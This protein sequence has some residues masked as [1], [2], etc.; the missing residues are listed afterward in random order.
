MQL[1]PKI[2]KRLYSRIAD[3]L[4]LRLAELE[5]ELA[6]ERDDEVTDYGFATYQEYQ[7]AVR[8]AIKEL[9]A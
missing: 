2:D 8:A 5:D 3:S 4:E 9:R 6:D 1:I 7:I